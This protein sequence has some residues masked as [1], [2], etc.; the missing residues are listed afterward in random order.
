M[1]SVTGFIKSVSGTK[2][3]AVFLIDGLNYNFPGNFNPSV[4]TFESDNA[5]L[6][7]D[8]TN[9]LTSTREFEGQIG[10]TSV[11]ITLANGPTIEGTLNMPISPASTVS[12]TGVWTE[13]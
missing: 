7:Y 3:V 13:N 8:N 6:T 2:F 4:Q 12:G 11:K 10:T 1:P 9:E 5:T